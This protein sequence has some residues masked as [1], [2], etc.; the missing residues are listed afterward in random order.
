MAKTRITIQDRRGVRTLNRNLRLLITTLFGVIVFFSKVLLPPSI[1][2]MFVVVQALLLALSWLV[3]G[4]FGATYASMINGLLLTI[5]RLSFAPFSLIFSLVYGLTTDFFLSAFKARVGD[6]VKTVR[7][8]AALATSS[9]IT[10]LSSMYV[11]TT[12]GLVPMLPILYLIIMLA[13][14][15]NG[16]LAGYLT[17]IIWNKYL[18]HYFRGLD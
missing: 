15:L 8:I 10:G 5:L 4:S 11:T 13:G 12:L 18:I 7:T 6:K 1:G 14:I 2:D 17:P 16:A 3:V 9:A